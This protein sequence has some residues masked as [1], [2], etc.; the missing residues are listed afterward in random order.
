M[1]P[2]Q[3]HQLSAVSRLRLTTRKMANTFMLTLKEGHP[4]LTWIT[5]KIISLEL[6]HLRMQNIRHHDFSL[7][8]NRYLMLVNMQNLQILFWFWNQ[9]YGIIGPFDNLINKSNERFQTTQNIHSFIYLS[10]ASTFNLFIL[11]I[12]FHVFDS[13]TFIYGS[14]LSNHDVIKEQPSTDYQYP[15]HLLWLSWEEKYPKCD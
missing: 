5:H 15:V 10:S 4:K 3:Q 9:A 14:D 12:N 11:D 1:C 13:M 2:S 7:L 6:V 8:T